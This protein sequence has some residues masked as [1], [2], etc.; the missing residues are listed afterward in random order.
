[1]KVKILGF[2]EIG[3]SLYEVYQRSG[4]EVAWKDL[5]ISQGK[6]ECEILNVCI[7]YND[8]FVG[9]VID[10]IHSS[11]AKT[12]IIHSTVSP[13]V[14]LHI[15]QLLDYK[16]TVV[17][18][19]VIGVHPNLADGIL[20]FK[21]WIG[22]ESGQ[23]VKDVVKHFLD[24]GII[25][26]EAVSPSITTELFK[27]FDTTYYGLC[28][29][30]NAEAEEW[31]KEVD[32]SYSDWVDYLKSY[33]AGYQKLGMANVTR[34]YFEHLSMPIGGHCVTPNAKLINELKPF[35]A[36]EQIFKYSI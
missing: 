13:G 6:Q 1:M 32:V 15:L 29:A 4:F 8:F 34:P 19:P 7:P 9:A 16:V 23:D 21:K 20:T 24:I 25:N 33:N 26:F 18:S 10:E 22:Y 30:L 5:R 28:L 3:K 36:L 12:V 2:G 17:H 35:P 11:G 31:F 14:T 27:V